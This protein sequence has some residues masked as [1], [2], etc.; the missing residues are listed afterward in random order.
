VG[1]FVSRTRS[2]AA[3]RARATFDDA[4]IGR[5][6]ARHASGTWL[7]HACAL[8]E[9]SVEGLRDACV[10]EPRWAVVIE[11]AHAEGAEVMRLRML[12]AGTEEDGEGRTVR[13][14]DWKREAH[15][16]ERWDPG[17]F[18]LVSKSESKTELTGKDGA[19]LVPV[20]PRTRAETLAELERLR[21]I[22]AETA[23]DVDDIEKGR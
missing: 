2:N 14:G 21:Q 1:E 23:T 3:S 11:K 19:P 4:L 16:L 9:C 8:E 17:T 12:E 10:R 15:M 20:V 22:A 6:A 13:V 18:H 5:I 7:K